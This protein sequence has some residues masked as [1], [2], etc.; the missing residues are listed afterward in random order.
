MQFPKSQLFWMLQSFSAKKVMHQNRQTILNSGRR[1][2][3]KGVAV[4]LLAFFSSFLES[5]SVKQNW[6]WMADEEPNFKPSDSNYIFSWTYFEVKPMTF[7]LAIYFFWLTSQTV[8]EVLFKFPTTI[9]IEELFN[10]IVI[11]AFFKFP[12]TTVLE[13]LFNLVPNQ[14][15][16]LKYDF[17]T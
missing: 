1:R 2:R 13:G 6:N 17:T 5:K 7:Y 14:F 10:Q 12:K 15:Y 11:E 16:K 4:V 8:I 3:A 9:V